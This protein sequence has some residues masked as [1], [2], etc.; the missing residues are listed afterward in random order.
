ML[1][2][3]N[4]ETGR[5]HRGRGWPERVRHTAR[6]HDGR[7]AVHRATADSGGR[8]HLPVCGIQKPSVVSGAVP[9]GVPVRGQKYMGRIKKIDTSSLASRAMYEVTNTAVRYD[10]R[11]GAVYAAARRQ[12]ADRH[13]LAIVVVVNKM[14]TIAWHMLKNRGT[15]RF[16]QRESVPM[17]AG[18]DGKEG[19]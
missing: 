9:H 17:Q 3:L 1:H 19:E 13:A 11:M 18:Q 6:G 5:A 10:P 15:V 8:Q 12:R 16:P 2:L 4:R 7:W 14:F